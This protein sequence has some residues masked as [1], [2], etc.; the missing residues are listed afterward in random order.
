MS[1]IFIKKETLALVF[2]CEFYGIFKN[3]H[4]YRTPLVAASFGNHDLNKTSQTNT[5][6]KMKFSI[7]NFFSKCDQIY[8]KQRIR[9]HL[10]KK[11]SLGNFIFCAVNS[12]SESFIKFNRSS[13]TLSRS[14]FTSSANIV[15]T[16][17][18][19]VS[20]AIYVNILFSLIV[21]I[22]AYF[23]L[24]NCSTNVLKLWIY[25]SLSFAM[26]S[27]RIRLIFRILYPKVL[28]P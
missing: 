16:S 12:V 9:S 11:S 26:S 15:K 27:Q 7:K 4:F 6:Q 25:K 2:S 22:H 28:C 19:P 18:L 24:S 8:K 14:L 21:Q 17:S 5:A 3:T 1:C 13:I 23:P 20:I 10:L